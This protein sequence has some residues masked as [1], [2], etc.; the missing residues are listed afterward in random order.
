MNPPTGIAS[1]PPARA[2]AAAAAPPRLADRRLGAWQLT[3]VIHR[4]P[5]MTLFRARPL[6][7]TDGPGCYLVKAA[8]ALGAE[9][10]V[11]RAMIAREET[12]GAAVS[13]ANLVANLATHVRKESAY[14]VRP[15]LEGLTLREWLARGRG[16]LAMATAL[17]IIRQMAEALAALHRAEWLHGQVRPEH[18]LVSPQGHATLLDLAL[19]RRLGT[20]ECAAG[21]GRPE[22]LAHASPESLSASGRVTAASDTY[23]LGLLLY[24]LLAGRLPFDST[25]AAHLAALHRNQAPPDVRADRPDAP[26]ELWQ[27]LRLML[28]KEPLRRPS[29]EELVRWLTELEIA[30]LAW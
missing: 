25:D 15:Y 30:A 14:V 23:C 12:V 13:H 24:E 5:R 21:L 22:P 19:A 2:M 4:G 11:A 8:T 26:A 6:K 29:D 7:A 16:P 10:E 18:V 17:W 27:L 20:D 1:R 9:Q 28:A 3:Q